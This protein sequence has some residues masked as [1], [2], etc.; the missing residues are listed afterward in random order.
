MLLLVA[1][2]PAYCA[3]KQN[4]MEF[5]RIADMW[6][7]SSVSRSDRQLFKLWFTIVQH[8]NSEWMCIEKLKRQSGQSLPAATPKT[9]A[10]QAE[11]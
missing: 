1:L 8:S 2:G 5:A 4:T 7:H 6:A 9:T 10:L 3:S 11:V